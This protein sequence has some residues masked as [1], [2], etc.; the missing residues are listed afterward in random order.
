VDKKDDKLRMYIDYHALNKIMINNN[1]LLPH[2][3]NMLDQFN[4]SKYFS[5]IDFKFKT[6][7]IRI[8]NEDVEKTTMRTKYGSCE[9]LMVPFGLCNAPLMFTTLMDSIFHEKLNKFVIIY[10]DDILVYSKMT[11]K[12]AEH[13]EYV[14]SKLL[15]NIIL[16]NKSKGEFA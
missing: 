1:Y 7:Q 10:I 14:L 11:K 4:G 13:L 12:H 2:I 15:E 6:Y 5:R 16:A 3:D 9:F 8:T